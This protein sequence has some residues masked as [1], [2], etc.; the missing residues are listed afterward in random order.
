MDHKG[1]PSM[2]NERKARELRYYKQQLDMVDRLMKVVE[3]EDS[4]LAVY[5]LT[6]R[7]II[8]LTIISMNHLRDWYLNDGKF[9]VGSDPDNPSDANRN[10]KNGQAKAKNAMNDAING[11]RPL[12]LCQILANETKHYLKGRTCN[13]GLRLDWENP[14]RILSRTTNIELVHFVPSGDRNDVPEEYKLFL[15][16]EVRDFLR[17]CRNEWKNLDDKYFLS[18]VAIEHL[19]WFP[20]STVEAMVEGPPSKIGGR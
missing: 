1:E 4:S 14:G 10:M 19:D 18:G 16:M 5:P 3:S 2:S 9:L 12:A 15:D 6:Y 7:D 11:S 17:R 20:P 13:P 8:S